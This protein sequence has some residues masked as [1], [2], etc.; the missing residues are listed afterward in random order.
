MLP[1]GRY[2]GQPITLVPDDYLVWLAGFDNTLLRLASNAINCKCKDCVQF[3]SA[4][5]TRTDKEV[6]NAI[7]DSFNDGVMPECVHEDVQRWWRVYMNYR[8]WVH[9]ARE[10]FKKRGICR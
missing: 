7:R 6:F 4:Y 9:A 3:C 1:F 2:R 5:D 10:E 8:D